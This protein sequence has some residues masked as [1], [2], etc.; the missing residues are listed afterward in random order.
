MA[1]THVGDGVYIGPRGGIYEYNAN[2]QA[3][4]S[5]EGLAVVVAN[6]TEL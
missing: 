5:I 4:L 1:T 3:C 2:G 6:V